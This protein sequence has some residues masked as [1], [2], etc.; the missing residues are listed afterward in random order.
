MSGEGEPRLPQE[1]DKLTTY[2]TPSSIC[3][4]QNA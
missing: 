3:A 4:V 1:F 2:A